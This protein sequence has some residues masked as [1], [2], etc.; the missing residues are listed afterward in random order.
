MKKLPFC[1]SAAGVVRYDHTAWSHD[2]ISSPA[3]PEKTP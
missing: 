2:Y 1:S 3:V